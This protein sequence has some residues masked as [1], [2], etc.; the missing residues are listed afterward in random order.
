MIGCIKM[1]LNGVNE[2]LSCKSKFINVERLQ[3]YNSNSYN[4]PSSGES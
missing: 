4:S 1:T 3:K 2:E